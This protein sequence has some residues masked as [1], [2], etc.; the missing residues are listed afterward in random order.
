M[1]LLKVIY[2]MKECEFP[3]GKYSSKWP[4]IYTHIL[5][6]FIYDVVIIDD[7]INQYKFPLYF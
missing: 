5:F 6:Y 7:L 2:S 1:I 4:K 3:K